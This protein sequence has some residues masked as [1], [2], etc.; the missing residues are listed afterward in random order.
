MGVCDRKK[1]AARNFKVVTRPTT[2][3]SP[4]TRSADAVSI[5]LPLDAYHAPC[6]VLAP[7][8]PPAAASP[9]PA[10]AVRVSLN[11]RRDQAQ[12]LALTDDDDDGRTNRRTDGQADVGGRGLAGMNCKGSH[13]A[14]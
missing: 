8:P 2:M 4:P 5:R 9:L 11:W 1:S 6:A 3:T 7:P 12:K 13:N 14:A 10:A